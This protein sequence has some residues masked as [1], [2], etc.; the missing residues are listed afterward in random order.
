MKEHGIVMSGDHPVKIL[1]GTKTMTRRV[2]KDP[3]RPSRERDA[4]LSFS[5]G[6]PSMGDIEYE[7]ENPQKPNFSCPYGQVGDRLWGRE[8][9]SLTGVY[10]VDPCI[11]YR[12]D[13]SQKCIHPGAL[14]DFEKK[15]FRR[16]VFSKRSGWRSSR[17]MPRWAS[18]ITLEITGV[19]VERLQDISEDDAKAEGVTVI[20]GTHQAFAKNPDTGKLELIG[21][22]EPYTAR[23]HFESLWDSINGKIHPWANNDW[24]WVISFKLA[25]PTPPKEIDET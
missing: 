22:P 23:Y 17:F 20:Q 16:G 21:Q 1:N 3:R 10:A 2:A 5:T 8:T 14:W 13:V 12:A 18:R 25:P 6:H 24:V 7:A 11:N 15:E 19:M 9:W 4:F